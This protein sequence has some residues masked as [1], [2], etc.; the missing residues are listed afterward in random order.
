MHWVKWCLCVCMCVCA[1]LGLVFLGSMVFAWT[2]VVHQ[3]SLLVLVLV[4]VLCVLQ[5]VKRLQNITWTPGH[6][7]LSD[8]TS[9]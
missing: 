1:C 2:D 3:V 7:H 4:A 6:K 9:V 5:E 8:V